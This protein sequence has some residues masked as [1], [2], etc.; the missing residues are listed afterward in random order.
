M[1]SQNN[2]NKM[3]MNN[4]QEH[5][6]VDL[7]LPSGT[8]W[9]TCNVGASK[10]EDYGDHF[11]W[12]ETKTKDVYYWDTYKHAKGIEKLTKYCNESDC[13]Y[14]GFADTL[15]E[16]Q[17]IDDPA[18][19]NWGSSCHTPTRAEWI[20]LLNNTSW[21]WRSLNDVN[22]I[23]FFSKNNGHKIFLPATGYSNV[24]GLNGMNSF[25]EYWSS[26]LSILDPRNAW[27]F[28]FNNRYYDMYNFSRH[29]GRSVRP[30]RSVLQN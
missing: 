5:E 8:L 29:Y 1:Q 26:S 25:G 9:A 28:Y 7:G 24:D 22:G 6:F 17:P 10:P 12:G 30:V 3:D 27:Y 19:A 23:M 14:N 15:T 11:A 16:L 18:T 2:Y 4:S 13:G 20:E 21:R